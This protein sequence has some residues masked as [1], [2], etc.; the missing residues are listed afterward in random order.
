MDGLTK[1][2]EADE[3]ENLKAVFPQCFTEGQLY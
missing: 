1:D 3:R 2:M